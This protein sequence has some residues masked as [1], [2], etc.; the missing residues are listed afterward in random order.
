MRVALLALTVLAACAPA[1]YAPTFAPVDSDGHALRDAEGR[2]QDLSRRQRPHRRHL[3]RHLRRRPRPARAAAHVRRLRSGRHARA[4]LQPGAPAHQLERHRAGARPVRRRLPRSRRRH[5]RLVPGRR[6]RR[7]HRSPRRRLVQGAV[8]GRRAAVGGRAAAGDAH[9]RPRARPRLP[10]D[11]T[12]R[13]PR[14]TASGP[15]PTGS[16][17]P[18]STCSGT[19]PAASPGDPAVI[20][21]EIMNEP[22]G[23][24]DTVQAFQTRAAA[25]AARRRSEEAPR[26]RARRHPQLHQRRAHLGDALLRRRRGLRRAHLHRDLRQLDGA[27]RRQLSRASGGLDHG[28]PRGGR[29]LGHAAHGHR[30]RPRL[31]HPRGTRRGSATRSTTTTRSAPRRR[32]GCGRTRRPAAGAS[33]TRSPTAAT[34]RAR[35]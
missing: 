34:R 22:I 35:R 1:K 32:G 6:G 10:L 28:R 23:V 2:V 15:T 27:R 21:Y 31:G 29:Q 20:G 16:R 18:T 11:R 9:R 14:S 26:L 24:D 17:R 13:W 4:R 5:R 30:V 7:A 19:S 8:R 3:R 33:S 12:R 25:D